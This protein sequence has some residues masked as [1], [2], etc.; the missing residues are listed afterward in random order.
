MPSK[1]AE[2]PIAAQ[3]LRW[4]DNHGRDLPWRKKGGALPDPYHVWLSEIMLQQTTVAA[5]APYFHKFL[6]RWKTVKALAAADLDEVLVAWA[7]LG[8][9]ARARN[10]H[11]CAKAVAALPYAKFP[12]TEEALRALPGIGAYTAAAIAA[13]AFNRHA[14]VVDGNVERVVTRLNRIET[15]LPAAKPEIARIVSGLTPMDRPGDFAQA[16]MDL[17]ATVCTP[18]NPDC[19]LCPL[20]AG[21]QARAAGLAQDLPRKMAKPPK[22][23]RR[24]TAYVAISKDDRV[25]LRRRPESGLLGGM[26][27]VPGTEWG[28]VYGDTGEAAPVQARWTSARGEVRHVFTHFEL[29]LRVYV[30]YDVAEQGLAGI[31]APVADLTDFALPNLMRKVIDRALKVEPPSAY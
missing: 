26:L 3:L 27:G 1:N 19:G 15:P 31:W 17:G 9:Y 16:M 23:V 29:N 13:I 7:G 20:N 18:R 30:A 4:Y 22:P 11:K 6:R 25:L 14:A 28:P 8:Y 12:E 24:G 5:V 2:P 21:C 10:L